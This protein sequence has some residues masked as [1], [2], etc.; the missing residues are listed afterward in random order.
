M[1]KKNWLW[2]AA[3]AAVAF[4]LYKRRAVSGTPPVT[5][6]PGP[7]GV[8]YLPGTNTPVAGPGY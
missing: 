3:I 5:S 1:S 2:F 4:W 7:F 6:V 8:V